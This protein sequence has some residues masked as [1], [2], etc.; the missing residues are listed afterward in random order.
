MKRFIRARDA[1]E[2]GVVLVIVALA[3]VVLIGML[4]IA[5]DASYGFVQNR[6]R[7]ECL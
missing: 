6:P 2:R 3:M 7:S 1:D 5:I 4:A